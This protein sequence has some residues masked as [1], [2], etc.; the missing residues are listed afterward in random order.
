MMRIYFLGK[1]NKICHR[2]Q[3]PTTNP[4]IFFNTLEAAIAMCDRD[5]KE[6]QQDILYFQQK[7]LNI[8]YCL[9][10]ENPIVWAAGA[11][12]NLAGELLNSTRKPKRADDL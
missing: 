12:L 11:L 8:L 5:D 9:L 7:R 1:I 10:Q 4:N 3:L 6:L 2:E